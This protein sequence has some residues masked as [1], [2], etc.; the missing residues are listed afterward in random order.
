M[1]LSEKLLSAEE[2]AERAGVSVETIRMFERCGLLEPVTAD[3]KTLYQEIDIRTVF[4]SRLKQQEQPTSASEPAP[5]KVPLEPTTNQERFASAG[6][7]YFDA[8][9]SPMPDSL[10][11]ISGISVSDLVMTESEPKAALSAEIADSFGPAPA[12][13]VQSSVAMS[14]RGKVSEVSDSFGPPAAP[15][16]AQPDPMLPTSGQLI[17]V[18]VGLREQIQVLREERDWLRSRVEN[19]ENRSEREQMLLLSES[20][21]IRR[22]VTAQDPKRSFWQRALPWF[23]KD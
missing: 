6:A 9:S 10:V 12:A 22:L 7:T 2:S 20:E 5:P 1:S 21:T 3:G 14:A 18:N 11:T 19:L 13:G 23:G 17:E 16:A 15:E 8:L 4:Y